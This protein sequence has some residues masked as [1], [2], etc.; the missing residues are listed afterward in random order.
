M[1]DFKKIVLSGYYGYWNAG[2]ELILN[3]IISGFKDHYKNIQIDVLYRK[4]PDFKRKISG[5]KSKLKKY[6][7]VGNRS[8]GEG[9]RYR[10]RYNPFSIMASG[11]SLLQDISGNFTIYYYFLLMLVAKLFGKKLI[12]F[13]QGIGPIKRRSNRFF[14]KI[15]FL[16]TDLIIVRDSESKV[17]AEKLTGQ[18]KEIFLGADP[19]FYFADSMCRDNM[20]DLYDSPDSEI[21]LN[22]P[23][24]I[25][26]SIRQWKTSDLKRILSE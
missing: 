1:G 24:N 4:G 15:I 23:K 26:F 5:L 18:K 11:G 6:G 21:S 19:F 13:N 20:N 8:V 12:I 22:D 25:G 9:I 3:C 7:A 16:L 14:A 17:F 2:D 10:N